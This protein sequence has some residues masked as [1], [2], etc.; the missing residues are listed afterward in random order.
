MTLVIAAV[1]FTGAR[2]EIGDP[3][4]CDDNAIMHCGA[5]TGGELAEKY[6]ANASGD[7]PAIFDSY[8]LTGDR[9]TGSSHVGGYV[10]KS[11][12]VYAGD[13]LVATGAH[14][15]GR[16]DFGSSSAVSIGGKTYY[17]RS[18]STSFVSDKITAHVFLD[19]NGKYI[20]AILTSCGNPVRANAVTTVE[21]TEVKPVISE[22]CELATYKIVKIDEKSFD[23]SRYSKN[24]SD[25]EDMKVCVIV[26]KSIANIR[27][28]EFDSSTHTTDMADCQPPMEVC[29]LEDKRIVSIERGDYDASRHTTDLSRCQQV[30][31][32]SQPELP[33]TGPM[34][35]VSG[36]VGIGSLLVASYNWLISRRALL[37]G[38]F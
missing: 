15:L 26:T 3:R 35:M 38:N 23:A 27:K 31:V 33:K 19:G 6:S 25:C 10:T 5:L 17:E 24:M 20:G 37:S 8:G 16:Q 2:A 11:G 29:R 12:E 14:S 21:P 4:D 13:K 30:A 36:V 22:A 32:V 28:S 9:F 34:E 1:F 18:T 7:L